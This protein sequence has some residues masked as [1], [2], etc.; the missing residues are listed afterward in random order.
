M[1]LTTREIKFVV[2]DLE[3]FQER[4]NE[5][6]AI[7]E[8]CSRLGKVLLVSSQLAGPALQSSGTA[9][10]Y[11]K[12]T[13]E[14]WLFANVLRRVLSELELKPTSGVFITNS[15][16]NLK[17]AHELMLGTI[18]TRF[19]DESDQEVVNIFQQFPDF[20]IRP[21]KLYECLTG[22][23]VGFAG[24]YY[25][26][27]PGIFIFKKPEKPTYSFSRVP[28]LKNPDCPIA[29]AGRYFDMSDARYFLHA[30][31]ARIINSKNNPE[32]QA[33]CFGNILLRTIRISTKNDF[34]YITRVP[35]K[36]SQKVDRLKM[37][38]DAFADHPLFAREDYDKK[39]LRPDLLACEKEYHSLKHYSYADRLKVIEGVFSAHNDVKGKRI[40]LL[41]DVQTTGATL[42]EAIKT[43]KEKGAAQIYPVALA[44]HPYAVQTL[45]LAVPHHVSCKC[46]K[47]MVPR[48]KIDGGEPFYGCSDGFN[49]DKK[50]STITFSESVK[51][52][53]SVLEPSVMKQD[54]EV[55]AWNAQF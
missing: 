26:A 24:E 1:F 13:G 8:T 28:N 3:S 23:F 2:I 17:P 9:I 38:M 32:R 36:P 27:P 29:V 53:L 48:C 33:K 37:Y 14:Q 30:L 12:N 51:T 21:S 19:D 4:E 54:E 49:K 5:V 25:A 20:F 44:Y 43:L 46:G 35:P 52:Q 10:H 50:H 42:N 55:D 15:H 34:D 7:I 18:V 22:E 6:N 16:E 39:Q 41:D 47:K 45:A 11:A 40:V 31:S